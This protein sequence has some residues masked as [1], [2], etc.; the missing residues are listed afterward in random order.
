[1]K[2]LVFHIRA[3]NFF[4]G[5]ERQIVGHILSSHNF[6]H[7]VITFREAGRHNEFEAVCTRKQ[8]KVASIPTT[9]AYQW[10]SVNHL[11]SLFKARRP[12]LI[13]CHGY[14]PLVLT[15]LAKRASATPVVAFSRG[16]TAEN[17]KIRIFE[18]VERQLYRKVQAVVAVS[19]GYADV[20]VRHGIAPNRLT[21]AC[22][23]VEMEKFA[24]CIANKPHTRQA[25]GFADNDFLIATAG[26]LS[27]EKAQLDLLTAFAQLGKQKRPVHLVVCG[28]GPM[29]AHLEH[30]AE[31]LGIRNIHFLGHRTDLDA[32]M[33]IFD[34]FVLPSLTEGLP[35]VLLEAAA[36][37]VPLVA[38]SVGGV[39]EII[40]HGISGLL[41][42]PR[43][44]DQ[45][46][47]AIE[48]CLA[49]PAQ[50]AEFA[51]AAL[52]TV[53]SDFGFAKQARVLEGLYNRLLEQ[54]A[55]T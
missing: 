7:L 54:H 53:Q 39:P 50:T 18:A 5:P 15:F 51:E 8:I 20:L 55:G 28:D 25:L 40:T 13:C 14:K 37:R 4:G 49:D 12:S 24:S 3:S 10:A 41:I 43:N 34:L 11:R 33:P 52:Q 6:D 17:L 35:N 45:L 47:S 31:R 32:L 26:R 42:E 44:V 36:C 2:P 27:P 46:T 23:A 29:R 22:N 48:N 9:H 21:V 38:T 16:H 30:G 19:Q 1:M